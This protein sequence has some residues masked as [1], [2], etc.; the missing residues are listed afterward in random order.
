MPDENIS[1]NPA[2]VPEITALEKEN[3]AKYVDEFHVDKLKQAVRER[4]PY[5]LEAWIEQAEKTN[6]LPKDFFTTNDVFREPAPKMGKVVSTV[7]RKDA[8]EGAGNPL[9]IEAYKASQNSTPEEA[10]AFQKSLLKLAEEKGV[11]K[12]DYLLAKDDA[13]NTLAH[14][15]V[16]TCTQAGKDIPV[17]TLKFL[18]DELGDDMLNARNKAGQTP[19][20]IAE[21]QRK[22]GQGKEDPL[23]RAENMFEFTFIALIQLVSA[24]IALTKGNEAKK[25][26]VHD[27]LKTKMG[28]RDDE[29]K[30]AQRDGP[31][32]D[33][34]NETLAQEAKEAPDKE[35][36][37]SNSQNTSPSA[38]SSPASANTGVAREK[39]SLSFSETTPSTNSDAKPFNPAGTTPHWSSIYKD[40][41]NPHPRT[42][43]GLAPESFMSSAQKEYHRASAPGRDAGLSA[44]ETDLAMRRNFQQRS[45]SNTSG[46]WSPNQN[47]GGWNNAQPH[48]QQRSMG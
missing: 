17:E 33:N 18:H 47:G 23:M 4:K 12:K 7:M 6:R 21:E 15:I 26:S 36:A 9:A 31:K 19:F 43:G 40:T 14:H 11:S 48:P 10:V 2:L 45:A 41:N 39:S 20:E 27:E 37:P 30:I 1:Q 29:V 8:P 22:Q 46:T 32:K 44:Y 3:A 42:A 24:L 13:G 35:N 34:V 38:G 16:K 28:E 5:D 25:S